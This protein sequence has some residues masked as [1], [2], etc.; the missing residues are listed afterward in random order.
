MSQTVDRVPAP[1]PLVKAADH[2]TDH[3]PRDQQ[4]FARQD[5]ARAHSSDE[6]EVVIHD[7]A[8]EPAVVVERVT[9]EERPLDGVAAYQAAAR[10]AIEVLGRDPVPDD[11]TLVIAEAASPSW[12]LG[13]EDS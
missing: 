9:H 1:M 4:Q 6:H 12:K 13:S 2:S 5:D 7:G 10:H 11:E 8:D 3:N